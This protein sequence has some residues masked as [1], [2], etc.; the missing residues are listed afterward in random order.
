[1]RTVSALLLILLAALPADAGLRGRCRRM[2]RPE[3]ARCRAAGYTR[4]SCRRALVADCM[5]SG[6]T[7]CLFV[8]PTTTTTAI[9][10]ATTTTPASTTSTTTVPTACST[11]FDGN[12][13]IESCTS[14]IVTSDACGIHDG[15]QRSYFSVDG[16]VGGQLFGEINTPLGWVSANYGTQSSTAFTLD[17]GAF[18]GGDGCTYQVTITANNVTLRRPDPPA[19]EG[20]VGLAIQAQCGAFSCNTTYSG[21]CSFQ[22]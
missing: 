9:P 16:C 19:Y 1:M 17:T 8:P 18:D 4:A 3:V 12:W 14:G 15:R 6:A 20:P 11:P 13:Q 2:C 5:V 21:G 7:A 22:P 10:G